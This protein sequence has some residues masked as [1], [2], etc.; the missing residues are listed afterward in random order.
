[1]NVIELGRNYG[2]PN[3]EGFCNTPNEI[4]FCND[5]NVVEPIFAW[6]P[7]IATSDIV[8]YNHP[9]IPEWSNTILLTTLKN[10]S[11]VALALNSTGD[12]VVTNQT[13]FSNWWGRLRD[14]CIGNRGELYLITNGFAR[15]GNQNQHKIIKLEN[16]NYT[17]LEENNL[18]SRIKVYPNP[19]HN[20]LKLENISSGKIEI[21]SINGQLMQE[22]NFRNIIPIEDYKPGVYIIKVKSDNSV[23]REQKFIKY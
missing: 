3:V 17:S 22:M 15:N 1:V 23:I 20:F 5:S 11:V 8:V 7:T 19:A 10:Q 4:Q 9:A 13:Y 16:L 21:Y 14:V 2:W 12:S 18:N 6:S